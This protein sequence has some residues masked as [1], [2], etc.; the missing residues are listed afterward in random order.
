M[1]L[2]L[3]IQRAKECGLDMVI[4]TDG[5]SQAITNISFVKA[6]LHLT[7]DE[8]V[9]DASLDTILNAFEWERSVVK[10]EA[11]AIDKREK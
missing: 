9:D 3:A 8:S 5:R 1:D 11:D 2:T 6:V 7:G 4:H 10:A